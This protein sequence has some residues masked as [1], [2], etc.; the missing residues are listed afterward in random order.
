MSLC[1]Y[2]IRRNI[3][4]LPIARYKAHKSTDKETS[5]CICQRA[6]ITLEAAVVIPLMAGFLVSILFFFHIIYIQ[7]VMEEA[8]LFAGRKTAVEASVIEEESLLYASARGF[9]A[10]ALKDEPMIER[11]IENGN[12]GIVLLA[13]NLDEVKFSLRTYYKIRFPISFWGL[14]GFYMWNSGIFR[15]WT[16]D[17]PKNEGEAEAWV[18]V[19][20]TGTVYHATDS[21]Q[22]LRIC[23]HQV[24]LAEIEGVRGKNGQKYYA[25]ARCVAENFEYEMVYYTDYGTFY[26]GD[27][28]CRY[29]KRS[30]EKIA[31]SEIGERRPCAYCYGREKEKD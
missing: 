7:A 6:S 9:L 19:T 27:M 21:C 18:Y 24:R 26:H 12:L 14:D 20:E 28:G 8:V 29:I 11:Y 25:C 15:K 23:L 17:V 22:V 13:S 5:F 2:L 16:G 30:I 10:Y 4:I 31:R 1:N 3:I